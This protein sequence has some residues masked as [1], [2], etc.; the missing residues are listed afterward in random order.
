MAVRWVLKGAK[1]WYVG[2]ADLFVEL[3]LRSLITAVFR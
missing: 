1:I 2:F 3:K